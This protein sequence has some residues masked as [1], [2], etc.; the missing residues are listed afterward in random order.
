MI[1]FLASAF[2]FI[3]YVALLLIVFSF[4][5]FINARFIIEGWRENRIGARL[6]LARIGFASGLKRIHKGLKLVSPM[7]GNDDVVVPDRVGQEVLG[8]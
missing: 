7:S 5:V 6:R 4:A 3:I 8:L 1:T 2:H